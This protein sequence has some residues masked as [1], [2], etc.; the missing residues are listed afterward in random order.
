[1]STSPAT[2]FT[3][4]TAP[5]FPGSSPRTY[6]SPLAVPQTETEADAL[7]DAMRR[8]LRI[9]EYRRFFARE[10]ARFIGANSTVWS[11]ARRAALRNVLASAGDEALDAI[12]EVVAA[13]PRVDV[14]DEAEGVVREMIAQ[15][16]SFV[17]ALIVRFDRVG[18]GAAR[19]TI[20]RA[21][22][23]VSTRD[24]HLLAVRALGDAEPEVRDAAAAALARLGGAD[25]QAILRRRLER[26]RNPVV[27]EAIEDALAELQAA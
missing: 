23:D 8:R 21:L 20:V 10:L 25:A 26:E 27:R 15:S 7:L 17:S 19:A 3:A 11:A 5:S 12:L 16:P 14:S 4:T 22:Q 13:N 6:L 2:F 24:A 1:M 9:P 18:A